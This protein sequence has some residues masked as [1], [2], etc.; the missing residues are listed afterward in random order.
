[1]P[2]RAWPAADD[3]AVFAGQCW[4]RA[5]RQTFF[6]VGQGTRQAVFTIRVMLRPLADAIEAPWQARRLRDSLASMSPAVLAYKN[7]TVARAPLL[8]WLEAKAV[9]NGTSQ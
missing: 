2:A 4:L 9:E 6:P 1:M 3:P 8:R 7:L 5:E